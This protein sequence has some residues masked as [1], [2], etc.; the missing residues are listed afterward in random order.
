MTLVLTLVVFGASALLDPV[1]AFATSGYEAAFRGP[2]V[3]KNEVARLMALRNG[4]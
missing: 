2:L 4:R 1:G 3:H